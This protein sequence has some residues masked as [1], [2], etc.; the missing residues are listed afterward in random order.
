MGG[1]FRVLPAVVVFAVGW[2]GGVGG[3]ADVGLHLGGGEGGFEFGK[4]GRDGGEVFEEEVDG[5]G[6]GHVKSKI[7]FFD[8]A[9]EFADKG[10]VGSDGLIC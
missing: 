1:R 8:G 6:G 4:V 10:G 9:A 3:E 7:D 2:C 5:L